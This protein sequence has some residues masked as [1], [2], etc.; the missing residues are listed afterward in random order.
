[1]GQPFIELRNISKRFG[2]VRA[3]DNI[4]LSV[5]RGEILALLGENGSGK[6]TLMNMLSGIYTPDSGEIHVD[7]TQRFFASPRDSIDSGVGMVH[8]HFKLISVMNARE[9][10]ILGAG[11]AGD[12]HPL[13]ALFKGLD[14]RTDDQ[15]IAA[16]EDRFNIHTEHDRKIYAMSVGE[17]QTVE[18]LKMLYRGAQALILDEATAVLTPQETAALFD[19]MRRMKAAGCAIIFISHKLHEVMDISDR[20]AVL[21]KGKTVGTAETARTTPRELTELMVGASVSLEIR[22]E[23]IPRSDKPV[24]EARNLTVKSAVGIPVLNDLSFDLWGSEI[25][26][27]AGIAGSGQ[28]ELCEAIAGLQGLNGGTLEFLG[29]NIAGLSPRRIIKKG[30]RMSFVPEDRL[31]MG[32]AA[33]MS[34]TD[35]I[36]LKSYDRTPGFTVDRSA[37]RTKAQNIVNRYNVSTP[38]IHHVVKKLSGGNIQKV[39]LGREIEMEPRLFITAYPVR[40]LDINA[41]FSIYD[42]LNQQKQRGAAILYVGEDLDVL[43]ELCDRIMVI[44]NGTVMGTV[45]PETTT[46]EDIGLLMMG[47]HPA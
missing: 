28:K 20:V 36:L 3:N 34:I 33:G 32:L 39:L 8:Q 42:M 47:H 43:R 21:R 23:R 1:M 5:Y 46:K 7:G 6:S 40:G 45:D 2:S 4:N 26:G 35:N 15:K 30:I 41:S 16:V 13:P 38:S 27:V 17:K 14:K 31:G 37:G 44:H 11:R 12:G 29:E 22:R 19:M 25:L 9:N 18:I 24:L 10:I